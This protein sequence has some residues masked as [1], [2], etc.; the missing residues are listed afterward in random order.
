MEI[1]KERYVSFWISYPNINCLF[2]YAYYIYI[3]IALCNKTVTSR[4]SKV[5]VWHCR[6]WSVNF[7]FLLAVRR[8]TPFQERWKSSEI[9]TTNKCRKS[10]SI[11]YMFG[12][13]SRKSWALAVI[14]NLSIKKNAT[15]A[16]CNFYQ[17]DLLGAGYFNRPGPEVGKIFYEDWLGS[18]FCNYTA[19]PKNLKRPS[20]LASSHT[21]HQII[22]I[23][24]M[25]RWGLFLGQASRIIK[26]PLL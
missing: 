11:V 13:K 6:R 10:V 14:L 19:E 24:L 12:V 20:L 23:V 17:V 25:M 16:T 1:W 21:S 3:G 22:L 15:F 2:T 18:N 5:N 26:A 8:H 7:S 4:P 9:K